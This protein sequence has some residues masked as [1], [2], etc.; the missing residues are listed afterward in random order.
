MHS[1]YFFA[2]PV[3][4]TIRRGETWRNLIAVAPTLPH[5]NMLRSATGS[6]RVMGQFVAPWVEGMKK[7]ARC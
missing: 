6:A 4:G 2:D 5:R 3:F 7:P 1:P